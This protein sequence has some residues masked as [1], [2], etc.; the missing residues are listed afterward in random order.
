M[1]WGCS[2]DEILLEC[3]VPRSSMSGAC[4]MCAQGSFLSSSIA[5]RGAHTQPRSPPS[6]SQE[7]PV[8]H[9]DHS[10]AEE[11]QS[12]Q[13]R[14]Q[15]ERRRKEKG[16]YA[17]CV[18]PPCSHTRPRNADLNGA[19]LREPE[20]GFQ[21]QFSVSCCVALSRLYPFSGPHYLWVSARTA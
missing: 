8:S 16:F 1:P 6:H 13:C 10:H 17:S 7:G 15:T 4:R 2:A 12:P 5:S 18:P 3:P 20:S 14:H 21:F 19:L 11:C 9:L